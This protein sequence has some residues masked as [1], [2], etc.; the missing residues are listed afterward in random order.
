MVKLPT[1]LGPLNTPESRR[2]V[3]SYDVSSVR[4]G[5]LGAARSINAGLDDLSGGVRALAAE[6]ERVQTEDDRY[7]AVELDN[8]FSKRIAAIQYGD[9]T[10]GNPGYFNLQGEAAV[11]GYQGTEEAIEKAKQELLQKAPNRKVKQIFGLSANQRQVT[12]AEQMRRHVGQARLDAANTASETRFAT[13]ISDAAAAPGNQEVTNRSIAIVENETIAM[14]KRMGW[15]NE[16]IALKIQENRTAV[17]GSVIEAAMVNDPEAADALYQQYKSRISGPA[18]AKIETALL[19]QTIDAQA[20]SIAEEAMGAEKTMEGQLAYVR[21]HY[22]GKKEE[23]ASAEIKERYSEAWAIED[24]K[25]SLEERA[26]TRIRQQDYLD[27]KKREEDIRSANKSAWDFV[28]GGGKLSTWSAEHPDEFG[29]LDAYS[30]QKLESAEKNFLLGQ[31]YGDISDP[32]FLADLN[33]MK[34]G[35]LVNLDLFLEKKKF[36]NQGDY[37]QA[38]NL[39]R[40]AADRINTES[41]NASTYRRMEYML[42]DYAPKTGKPGSQKLA[43]DDVQMNSAQ[44]QAAAEVYEY[45]QKEGKAP[46]DKWL[47]ELAIKHMTPVWKQGGI[48]SLFVDSLAGVSGSYSDL[49]PED[50]QGAYIPLESIDPVALKNIKDDLKAAGIEEDEIL[51]GQLALAAKLKDQPRYQQLLKSK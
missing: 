50:Q 17:Y 2:G 21:K 34:P 33:Q 20:Q 42:K 3:A 28:R 12:E 41:N 38:L 4:S 16:T 36:G 18:R 13:A 25:W 9:G 7:K 27:S 15:N 19:T 6:A 29:A 51:I 14:G 46:D 5:M 26:I 24:R 32:K 8:E 11:T 40:A 31:E 10:A 45:I 35:D 1:T 23:A 44:N 39:Q 43:I 47:R 49:S 48:T 30:W 22:S 37:E